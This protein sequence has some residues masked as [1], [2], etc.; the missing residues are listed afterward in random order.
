MMMMMMMT[1]SHTG[2]Y[3]W[4]RMGIT[5]SVEVI[6]DQ[7]VVVEH[8]LFGRDLHHV[9]QVGFLVA[10]VV[11]RRHVSVDAH[12]AV[13]LVRSAELVHQLRYVACP[14]I[15]DTMTLRP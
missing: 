10:R 7:R 12:V 14:T 11:A 13:V 9:T 6:P 8:L 1:I 4:Q 2:K 15:Q 3:W 5:V